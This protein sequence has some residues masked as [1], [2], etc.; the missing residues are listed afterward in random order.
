MK[1]ALIGFALI[2]ASAFV[3]V[4]VLAECGSYF[5][6]EKEDTFS[7]DPICGWYGPITKTAHWRLFILMVTK[8]MMSR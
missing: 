5:Q 2:A 7:G 3:T 4:K 8:P 6:P 1:R